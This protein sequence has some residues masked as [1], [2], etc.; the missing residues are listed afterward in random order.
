LPREGD[1]DVGGPMARSAADLLL[2]LEIIAGPDERTGGVG[3]RLALPAP[4]HTKLAQYRA[5]VLDTHPLVPTSSAVAGALNRRV[6]LLAKAGVNMVHT[7]AQLPDFSE[8]MRL[9]MRLLLSALSAG[10]PP[11]A[12]ARAQKDA[13][14][15]AADDRSLEAESTRG[16]ALSHRDWLVADAMRR[17]LREQWRALFREVDVVLCP[18]MPNV[19]FAH[20]HSPFGARRIEIDGKAYSYRDAGLEWAEPA[21]T[22]GLPATVMPIDRSDDGLP[23]GMQI[24]GPFLEDRTPL[25]FAALVERAFGGFVAPPGYA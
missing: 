7:S 21:T 17:R 24:I 19:A 14:T 5:L 2:A 22:P 23:I 4:R 15:L 16:A 18:P 1:L 13:S 12:Y 11:D 3:Y 6:E 25:T 10:W 9:Y 8:S 20:D